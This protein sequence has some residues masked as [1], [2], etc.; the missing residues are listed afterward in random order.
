MPTI[1]LEQP[2][3]RGEIGHDAGGE[4]LPR[5]QL[6][7]LGADDPRVLQIALAPAPVAGREVDQRGRALL[8]GALEV[9]QHVDRPAG[10][11]HQRRLDEIVAEDMAAEGRLA[12]Q[13]R[14]AAMGGEGLGADDRVVAPVIAVAAHPDGKARGDDRAGDPGGELLERARRACCG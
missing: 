3:R 1:E 14:Q 12:L 9:G 10:A 5:R 11:P 7:A 8:V 13:V 2:E 4:M 6:Q